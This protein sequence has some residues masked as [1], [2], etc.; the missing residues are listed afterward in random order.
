M[1]KRVTEAEKDTALKMWQAGANEFDIARALGRTPKAWEN[2]IYD[3]RLEI[4]SQRKPIS[5]SPVREWDDHLKLTGDALIL[6]DF[7]TPYHHADFVNRVIDLAMAWGIKQLILA[8]D[9]VHFNNFSHWGDDFQPPALS[10]SG[11]DALTRIISLLPEDKRAEA[12]ASLEDAHLTTEQGGISAE[13]ASVR[14]TVKELE[15]AFSEIRYIMG[16]HE[17]RKL[18][19]QEYG[20]DPSELL[21]FF[22]ADTSKWTASAYYWCTLETESPFLYRIEHPK[23]A[24]RTMAQDLAVQFQQHIIAGHSHRFSFNLDPSGRLFAIQTGHVC[25]EMRLAYVCQRSAKR[26]AHALGATIVRAGRPYLLGAWADWE[27]LKRM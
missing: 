21:R 24:G 10:Q 8:G 13:M 14:T 6:P 17:N 7:E 23:P 18:R 12:I 4:K 19:V 27:R 5:A 20:E 9:F 3:L 15:G 2:I 11:E 26:D 25:D 16:N 22:G 1:A